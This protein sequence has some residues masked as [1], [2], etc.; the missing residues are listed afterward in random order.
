MNLRS[1]IAEFS[2]K[3][4]A[5]PGLAQARAAQRG[6][7]DRRGR[8]AQGVRLVKLEDGDQVAAAGV[9]PANG[10]EEDDDSNGQGELIQ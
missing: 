10:E 8:A 4:K 1:A 7:V 6:G 3:C 5:E 2:G 9:V